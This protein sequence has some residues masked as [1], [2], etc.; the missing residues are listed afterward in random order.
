MFIYLLD[1]NCAIFG[2]DP[3]LSTIGLSIVSRTLLSRDFTV[4][5]ALSSPYQSLS[6]DIFPGMRLRTEA[7]GYDGAQIKLTV[8]SEL[9]SVAEFS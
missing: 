6:L 5:K 1:I 9:T 7:G 8:E 4:I 3:F 2:S